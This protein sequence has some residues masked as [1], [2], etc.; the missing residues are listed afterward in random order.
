M[1]GSKSQSDLILS[2]NNTCD[3]TGYSYKPFV[4]TGGSVVPEM[5]TIDK[6]AP[7]PADDTGTALYSVTVTNLAAN[8]SVSV[9]C[10]DFAGGFDAT[11][12]YADD[13]GRIVLW[14]APTNH[15]RRLVVDGVS[16]ETPYPYT[17]SNDRVLYLKDVVATPAADDLSDAGEPDTV[18]SRMS[19][20]GGSLSLT[21]SGAAASRLL[22]M[23]ASTTKRLLSAAVSTDGALPRIYASPTL[24]FPDV[25]QEVDI[26]ECE[27]LD[28]GDGTVT[29]KLPLSKGVDQMFFMIR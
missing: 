24:P 9:S 27:V 16:Y 17:N 19:M 4:V 12:I 26:A 5:T 28:N 13:A 21:L 1:G 10:D 23:R 11:E 3:V 7:R 20:E 2:L 25:P 8:A 29:V 15:A 6:V 18:V 14:L 22:P